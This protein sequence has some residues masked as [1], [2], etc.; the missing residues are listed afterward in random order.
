MMDDVFLIH[1]HSEV[2][3]NGGE[4]RGATSIARAA[5]VLRYQ[6]ELIAGAVFRQ[7]TKNTRPKSRA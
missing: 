3:E 6:G 7:I 2:A 1:G 5:D 4:L